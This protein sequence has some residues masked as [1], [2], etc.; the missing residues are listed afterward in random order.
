[1]QE[2]PIAAPSP[3]KAELI[4]YMEEALDPADMTRVEENLRHHS[5]WREALLDLREHVD[6]GDHSVTMVWRRHRLT[7][8]ARERLYAWLIDALPPD[9]AGY[10]RFHL[11]VVKCRWC[12]AN[13]EDMKEAAAAATQD[14]PA[15]SGRSRRFFET[16]VGQ[17]RRQS[18]KG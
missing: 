4:G 17:L 6:S 2:I 3:N 10:V 14:V 8:P 13:L 9:A 12:R 11:D 5:G 1:M 18:S 7:C 15:A 16:S